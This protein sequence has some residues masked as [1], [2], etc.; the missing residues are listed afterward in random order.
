MITIHRINII[1]NAQSTYFINN[2]KECKIKDTFYVRTNFIV[3][4]CI[5]RYTFK[6]LTDCYHVLTCF[7]KRYFH[8]KT[9]PAIYQFN[10]YFY[11]CIMHKMDRYN[12]FYNTLILY[13]LYCYSWT[14]MFLNIIMLWYV[15]TKSFVQILIWLFTVLVFF[16]NTYKSIYSGQN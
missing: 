11:S 1:E 9:V 14:F 4:L 10:H 12:M 5:L 15:F 13:A 2:C 16:I 7:V 3:S 8:L 6:S